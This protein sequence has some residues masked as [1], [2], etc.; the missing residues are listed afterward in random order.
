M[1]IILVHQRLAQARTFT[2]RAWHC[3]LAA[4][5]LAL[6]VGFGAAFLYWLTFTRAADSRFPVVRELLLSATEDEALSKDRFLRAN[7][8]A[9]AVK[10]GE[11]QAQ[12]LRLD[13]LGERVSALAGLKPGEFSPAQGGGRG[14]ALV[15]LEAA[16]TLGD[17]QLQLDG[18][19][20]QL[21]KRADYLSILET[22]LM[23]AKL[24]SKMMPTTAPVST[25]YNG[26]AFGVRFDP[27]TGQRAWHQGVDFVAPPGTPI[28]A[29]A[30]GVVIAA[31]WHPTFGNM[32]D[33]DHGNDIVTR[34]AHAS[35][36][37]V[38][39]GEIVR[40]NQKIATVGNTGRSTGPHLHFEVHVKSVPQNP[41]KFLAA[42]SARSALSEGIVGA[43]NRAR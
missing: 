7:L 22:E 36:L 5:T 32:V 38:K 12:L 19:S 3:L 10:L 13:A 43:A 35:R 14:G 29:A 20:A 28:M 30:G 23:N 2:L 37:L 33:I 39:V 8:N 17:F 6:L 25:G 4:A 24:R 16:S 31:E 27:I 34:Y 42:N 9:M 41:A 15:P 18:L 1:Q 11:M 40:R 26:S 21:E